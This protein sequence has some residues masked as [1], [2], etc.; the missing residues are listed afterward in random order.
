MTTNT[1]YTAARGRKFAL[2]IAIAFAVL[3]LLSFWRGRQTPPLV[4]G[5]LAMI[6]AIAGLAVPSKLGPLESAWMKLAHVLSKVTTP[7]FMGIVYFVV[8]TPIGFIRRS[9]GGNPLVHKAERESY[10]IARA[11]QDAGK[12]R[13]RM[14]RQF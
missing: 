4:L 6:L 8:L 7:I 11:P 1:D 13:S 14:E 2:T 5:G 10:W 12:L 3:A 9:V